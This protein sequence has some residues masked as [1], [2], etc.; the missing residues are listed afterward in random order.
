MFEP[1]QNDIS[2]IAENGSLCIHNHEII[3]RGVIDRDLGLRIIEASRQYDSCNCLVSCEDHCYTDSKDE[4]FIS[5][6]LNTIKY[7]M[8]VVDDLKQIQKPFLKI[9]MCDF[10]TPDK[11]LPFFKNQ[12]RSEI[13]VVTSGNI[14]VDFIAP[15]ANKGQALSNLLAHLHLSASDGIAF[16]DQYNDLEM[17]ELAGTGYAMKNA[18]PGVSD[19]ADKVTESAERIMREILKTQ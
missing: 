10:H 13:K 16:G 5:H 9:A 18:A 8:V 2:Y 4:H 15:N 17:L 7:D 3:S 1:V 6:I 19:H 14:W 12:F 11:L